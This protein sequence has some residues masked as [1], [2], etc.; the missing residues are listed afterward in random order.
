VLYC[1]FV[2]ALTDDPTTGLFVHGVFQFEWG[3]GNILAGPGSNSLV[4]KS[5]DGR[6]NGIATYDWLSLC[7][8]E[9]ETR[10]I[11]H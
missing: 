10:A 8:K 7:V 5:I 3:L 4:M 2:T 11:L 6:A 9:I 1:R